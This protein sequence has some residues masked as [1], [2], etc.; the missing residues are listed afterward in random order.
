MA[1]I[2][3]IENSRYLRNRL[4]EFEEILCGDAYWPSKS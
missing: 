3:K 2:M 4:A 1:A